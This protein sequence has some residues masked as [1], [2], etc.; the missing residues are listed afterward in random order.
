MFRGIQGLGAGGLMTLAFTVVSDAFRRV[1]GAATR[2]S[3]ARCS[4]CRPW[5]ARWPAATSPKHDWRWIF[6]I[7]LPRAWSR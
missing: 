3:S 7:N 2:A 4:A 1:S 6:Y 5:S